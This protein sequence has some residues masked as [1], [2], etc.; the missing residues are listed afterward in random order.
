[1]H[2]ELCMSEG[3][4][5]GLRKQEALSHFQRLQS[6]VTFSPDARRVLD[7]FVEYYAQGFTAH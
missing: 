3:R 6:H 7:A 5:Y 4:A 2:T 1:M